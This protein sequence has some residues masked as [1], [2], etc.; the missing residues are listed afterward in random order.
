MPEAI[1]IQQ[2]FAKHIGHVY[3]VIQFEIGMCKFLENRCIVVINGNS[4]RKVEIARTIGQAIERDESVTDKKEAII[5]MFNDLK[6]DLDTIDD[7]TIIKEVLSQLK[8]DIFE[9][10]GGPGQSASR[11]STT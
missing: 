7:P 3:K 10:T 11:L 2:V 8:E 4:G 6:D 1:H 9:F 5:K